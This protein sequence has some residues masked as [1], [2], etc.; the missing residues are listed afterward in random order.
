MSSSCSGNCKSCSS[1]GGCEKKAAAERLKKIGKAVLVLSGKGGVGKSTVAAALAVQLARAGKRVGL[2]DVDFHGPSQPTLFGVQHLRADATEAGM[3]PL[4]VAGGV[5]LMSLALLLDEPDQAVIWR[6]P[7]KMG[8]I[9]QLIEEVEWGELDYLVLDF[10]P[11]TGDESLSACQ[12]LAID[13]EAVV[14]TTPQ[15]V[16]LADC[17]K[18]LD[19]CNQ[20]EVP[21]AGI[22]ENM[23]GFV[24]SVRSAGAAMSSSPPAAASSWPGWAGFRCW[25]GFRSIRSFCRA[26]TAVLWPKDCWSRRRSGPSWSM[27]PAR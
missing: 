20:V 19:F 7:V 16:A 27:S 22:V 25:R 5:R 8:V 14:V 18:C 24:C 6:G 13:K 21:V 4:E 12:L 2:L 26:A 23:S 15:E 10:P 9:K 3:Q 17:R 11:G 1:E